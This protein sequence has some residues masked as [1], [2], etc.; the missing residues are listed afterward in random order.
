ML[1]IIVQILSFLGIRLGKTCWTRPCAAKKDFIPKKNTKHDGMKHRGW[2]PFERLL[3]KHIKRKTSAVGDPASPAI[4][5][6]VEE[7]LAGRLSF[8]HLA[9]IGL[10]DAVPD[11]SAICR[12]RNRSPCPFL[13][14]AL[15]CAIE[16]RIMK[17]LPPAKSWTR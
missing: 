16:I 6:E 3:K 11:A 12:F 10:E 17:Y 8:L 13:T 4:I 1:D 2:A 5:R 9:G 7:S 14:I 15:P